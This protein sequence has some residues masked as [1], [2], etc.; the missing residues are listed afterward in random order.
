V[1]RPV[2]SKQGLAQRILGARDVRSN[3]V[4]A[5]LRD[6]DFDDDDSPPTGTPR[7]W[8]IT[9]NTQTVQIGWSWERKEIENYLI[10]PKVVRRALGSKA[11]SINEYRVALQNSAEVIANYTAARIA[12]SLYFRNRPSPPNN[13]WGEERDF[14]E[15]YR[16]PKDKGL[17]EINCRSEV[18]NIIKQYEQK[19]SSP[20]VDVLSQ[21]N[22]LLPACWLDGSRF[23]NQNFLTF[24]AGTD[25][26]YGMRNALRS[27]G[28]DS[29]VVFR[30]RILKGIE[31]S[32][33]E[34][35][36]WLPEWQQLRELISN[37]G[38]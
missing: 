13:F 5:G 18:N 9:D 31:E 15:G 11:P 24:F 1:V 36:T 27:F 37:F 26:L 16:F 28:F 22:R 38:N 34:M 14:K 32:D 3:S 30:E 7:Q 23:Q 12:L 33:E 20:K 10:D 17:T 6:R 2:G 4:I 35:W 25:L 29:P 8:N 21:F 19:L